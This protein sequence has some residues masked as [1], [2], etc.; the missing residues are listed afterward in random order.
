MRVGIGIEVG[1]SIVGAKKLED[2]KELQKSRERKNGLNS[3]ESA[4]GKVCSLII[5]YSYLISTSSD[6]GDVSYYRNVQ[7]RSR[8]EMDSQ[9]DRVVHS[10]SLDNKGP[11]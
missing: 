11:N 4:V 10:F 3:L 8:Q 1:I 2:V 5:D 9:W 6:S 7:L